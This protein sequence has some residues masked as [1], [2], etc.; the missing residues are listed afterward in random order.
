MKD[1]EPKINEKELETALKAVIGG[2]F[3]ASID[4]RK[5]DPMYLK[6]WDSDGIESLLRDVHHRQQVITLDMTQV[7]EE[8]Y[9]LKITER[10]Y[11][12]C[13]SLQVMIKMIKDDVYK[14]EGISCCVDK[15]FY[16]VAQMLQQE[17]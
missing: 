6:L 10:R 9:K 16:I 12:L 17:E 14:K 11:N 15:A 7:L 5:K 8:K 4:A 2:L 3:Q 13:K 1:E